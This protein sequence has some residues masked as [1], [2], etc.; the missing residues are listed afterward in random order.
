MREGWEYKK[1][2]EVGTLQRGKGIQKTDF[3]EDGQPCIH[4]G[5]L[6]T[7]FDISTK[8]HLTTIPSELYK[9][10]ILAS[11]GDVL[12][13]L[14]SEDVEGSCKSTAWLGNYDIAVSSDA[15]ILKHSLNPKF[16]VY[17]TR[18]RSFFIEKSKYARGFKVTHIKTSDIAKIPI[19]VPPIN[20]QQSIVSELDKINEL[21]SLKKSQLEDLDSLAQ[22]IFYDMF[23]DPVENEKGW[24]VKKLGEIGYCCSGGT[25]S[26]KIPEYFSGNI[27]W[28]SA[29][30]LNNL[31]IDN[32][33]EKI[34]QEA[35]ESSAAKLCPAKSLFIGMYDTAA[36]KM[37]IP[38]ISSCSNQACANINP[39]K[40]NVIY[41]YFVLQA[42]KEE[43]LK[44]RH[45]VRQK[46]LNL[47]YIKAFKIP[48]PPLSLQQTFAKRIEVIEQQ[49]QQ[50]NKT[51]KYLETLLAS[52][53]QYWF[54]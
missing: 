6:H 48:L 50:I 8:T 35:L 14:T 42:M 11:K 28:F 49:K 4:Y 43:A 46:N 32:S 27:N 39:Y 44:S 30:E 45:G 23:G 9:N 12:L 5:Q 31:Y 18:S 7:A 3:I 1:L 24:E 25:P 38:K 19:P 33:I 20:I 26:R 17:Y 13:A 54:D 22:S 2:G 47:S 16:I 52:R 41:L 36:F 10:S 34:T 15:V 40:D 29:G 51:I 37:S 21:I 53:M